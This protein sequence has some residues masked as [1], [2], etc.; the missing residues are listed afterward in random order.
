[1]AR[2]PRL[3]MTGYH[4]VVNRGVARSNIFTSSSDKDKFL[5]ILCKVCKLYDIIVHDYCLMGNHYH[6]L[7]ETKQEN[8]SLLM[9]QVN[10]YYAIYFNKKENRVGHLWQGRFR[11]WYV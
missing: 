8:L 9:R 5:Q 11:S 3:D 4:H 10:S 7:L 1:M 2:R 6:L